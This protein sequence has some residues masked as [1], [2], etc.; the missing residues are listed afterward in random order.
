[1]EWM[2]TR[3]HRNIQAR[4]VELNLVNVNIIFSVKLH[5]KSLA[6]LYRQ[7]YYSAL[8][9]SLL[10]AG[11]YDTS[12]SPGLPR[13]PAFRSLAGLASF[14]S[15]SLARWACLVCQL[16]T[17]SQSLPRLPTLQI[18]RLLHS[19]LY[20]ADERKNTTIY[21]YLSFLVC[22]RQKKTKA[23]AKM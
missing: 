8:I 9:R 4:Q 10:I 21:F 22:R 13:L 5:S 12:C 1:M 3:I 6:E 2:A 17:H 11:V 20:S 23:R 18:T 16:F 19:L 15:F 7:H 14:T